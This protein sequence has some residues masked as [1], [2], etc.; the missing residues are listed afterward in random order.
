V[1][2]QRYEA[3]RAVIADGAT[4]TDVA[5]R[6]GVSRK[7]VTPPGLFSRETSLELLQHRTAAKAARDLQGDPER[8]GPGSP[9][10]AQR[11]H[12]PAARDDDR[13]GCYQVLAPELHA[14]HVRVR[15]MSPSTRWWPRG[16]P[17]RSLARPDAPPWHLRLSHLGQSWLLCPC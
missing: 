7:T 4:V 5:A 11:V 6:F 9:G 15:R 17:C 14:R 12:E 13:S 2:E 3:L 1:A 8:A 16:R 10:P